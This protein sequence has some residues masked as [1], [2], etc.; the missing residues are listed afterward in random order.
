M[1]VLC[2]E[3]GSAVELCS[4]SRVTIGLFAASL[5]DAL[6]AQ[7][8]SFGVR[9]SLGRFSVVPFGYDRFD[10]APRDHQRFGYFFIT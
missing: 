1:V 5:I 9:P 2:T 3:L 7:S 10:G 6:L 8:V 4:S